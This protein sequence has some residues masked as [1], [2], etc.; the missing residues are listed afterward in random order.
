M[1]N[2]RETYQCGEC[3]SENWE[4]FSNKFKAGI[5]CKACGHEQL[6]QKHEWGPGEKVAYV[7]KKDDRIKF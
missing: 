6:D 7:W 5:R 3:G 1:H 4:R 2:M